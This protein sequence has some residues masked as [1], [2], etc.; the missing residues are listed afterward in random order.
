[1]VELSKQPTSW[2]VILE[3]MNDNV[4]ITQVGATTH[5]VLNKAEDH[6]T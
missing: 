6:N 3:Q 4:F 2:K 5:V 1:M